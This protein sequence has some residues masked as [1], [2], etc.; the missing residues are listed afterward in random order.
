M[1]GLTHK[2]NVDLAPRILKIYII[3]SI[4]FNLGQVYD[5][6]ILESHNVSIVPML[7]SKHKVDEVH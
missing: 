2:I 7:S 3:F 4:I 6:K 1:H 5:Q